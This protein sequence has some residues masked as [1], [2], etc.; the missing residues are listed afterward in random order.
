MSKLPIISNEE[1]ENRIYR[2]KGHNVMLDS[3]LAEM[4]G[5]ETRVL[6]QAVKR[7][8]KRFPIDFMFELDEKNWNKLK[9]NRLSENKAWGGRRTLP[10]VFTEHG[11][12]ML[13]SI[14]NSERAVQVNIQI[15]RIYNKLREMVVT[16][17]DILL[18]MEEM[19]KK[20][21][22]QDNEIK[23]IFNALKK[24]LEEPKQEREPIG[25]KRKGENK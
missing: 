3:D 10:R 16:H 8:I 6:N 5:V 17:K 14:L 1:I 11:V 19:E 2:I 13:S 23:V 12:L 7:N 22:K 15:M 9:E 18:K 20:I 25:F 24:L 21:G 4:Y